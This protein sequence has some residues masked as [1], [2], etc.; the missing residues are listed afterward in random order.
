MK[1]GVGYGLFLAPL[2]PTFFSPIFQNLTQNNGYFSS[3]YD[4]PGK[5]VESDIGENKEVFNPLRVSPILCGVPKP[6]VKSVTFV[7]GGRPAV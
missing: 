4:L 6:N 5:I 1:G 2:S 7:D 3:R